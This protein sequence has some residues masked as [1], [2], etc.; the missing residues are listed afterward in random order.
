[1]KAEIVSRLHRL[2]QEFYQTFARS[3]DS[4]R[5]RIQPGVRNLL[6]RVP[7]N[8]NWLDIGCGNGNLA[9]E[10]ARQNRSGYY[11]IDFSR[12]LLDYALAT[13]Q[14]EFPSEEWASRLMAVDILD[15]NWLEALPQVDWAGAFM[16]AVLHHIP[17]SRTRFD[18]CG[19]LRVLLQ[20]GCPLFVSV[21]QLQNSPRLLRRVQPWERAGLEQ[22][23]VEAGDVLM[24]WRASVEAGAAHPGLRYVH[25][26]SEAELIRLAETTGFTVREIF[27]SDGKEGNLALYQEWK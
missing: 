16:L 22:A 26:F 18:L 7:K 20:P 9:V 24:D 5:Q 12:R 1:M 4:T 25:L 27:F 17:G 21:W 3:F 11:G 23:D 10:W 2:N 19:Y 15:G 13:L 8:G 6:N 14:M